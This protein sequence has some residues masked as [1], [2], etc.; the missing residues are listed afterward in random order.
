MNDPVI[1]VLVQAGLSDEQARSTVALYTMAQTI[2]DLRVQMMQQ[3]P[4]PAPPD[5]AD[6][7]GDAP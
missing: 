5:A 3:P 1:D 4:E 7:G 6:E 2:A